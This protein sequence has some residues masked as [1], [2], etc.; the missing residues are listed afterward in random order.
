MD[1]NLTKKQAEHMID[2]LKV[3]GFSMYGFG[4]F[5]ISEEEK[6]EVLVAAFSKNRYKN[7]EE[8]YLKLY[9]KY[10]G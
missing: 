1:F 6:A 8:L 3:A 7:C 5:H 10:M 4:N 9:K 2:A